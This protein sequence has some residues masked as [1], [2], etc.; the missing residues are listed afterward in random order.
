MNINVTQVDLDTLPGRVEKELLTQ[1][2]VF[3]LVITYARK[4]A[5]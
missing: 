1:G 4:P 2:G 3:P 5:A